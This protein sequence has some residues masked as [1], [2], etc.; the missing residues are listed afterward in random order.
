MKFR[1]LRY[2]T[3]NDKQL[4][5]EKFHTHEE[6]EIIINNGILDG[7]HCNYIKIVETNII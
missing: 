5:G 4:K 7:K 6:T 2:V 1:Y 3:Q